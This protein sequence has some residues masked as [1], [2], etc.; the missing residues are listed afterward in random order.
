MLLVGDFE[1]DIS[2]ERAMDEVDIMTVISKKIYQRMV[3][4]FEIT[5]RSSLLDHIAASECIGHKVKKSQFEVRN[6]FCYQP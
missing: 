3:L 1:E 5:R 6:N 2:R 4:K